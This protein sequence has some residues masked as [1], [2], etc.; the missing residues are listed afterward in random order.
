[1]GEAVLIFPAGMAEGLAYRLRAKE[2]GLRVIGASSVQGD[3]AQGMYDI[4][5]SLPYVNDPGFDVALA[6]LV[7]RHGVDMVHTPHFVVWRHL[8]QRMAEIAP[9][10]RLSRADLPQDHE[11]ANRALRE[12]VA[13]AAA[14]DFQPAIAPRPALSPLARAGLI[15]LVDTIPGMCG[16]EKMHA[17]IEIMRSTPAGDIVE[18]GSCWG[19]SAALLVWLSHHYGLGQV[20][21]VD[22][23]LSEANV[24][25]DALLDAT[26]AEC[27]TDEAHR[28]FETN[29]A[30]L[31]GGRLNYIRGYSEDAAQSYRPGL[32]VRTEAFGESRYRGAIALLHIDGNHSEHHA[33]LDT[34]LWTPHV[35]PGGW[36]IFDDY[37]WAFGDGPRKVADAFVRDNAARISGVFQAGPALFIQLKAAAND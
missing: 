21:S 7:R 22:P 37:E 24:Q 25:G 36:I 28:M 18:I 10:A 31:A 32:V 12:R 2:L 5:E 30:P 1:V 29:L 34:R 17:V 26:A 16:E 35:V 8:S 33:D 14:P 13:A 6:E 11:R 23:W 3:P 20:L 4:W 27:D 15:R 19:R 9:G